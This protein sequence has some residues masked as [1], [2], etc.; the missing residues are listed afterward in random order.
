MTRVDGAHVLITGASRGIGR[1]LATEMARRGARVTLV[2]RD[3]D[4]L[5]ALAR[6]TGGIVL[7]ADLTDRATY[8]H[9][10]SRAE[11]RLGHVDVLINN[12]GAVD[13][14]SIDRQTQAQ[15]RRAFELNLLAPVELT[16]Q[17]LPGMV[18]RRRGHIVNVGSIAAYGAFPGLVAYASAK[19]GLSHFTAGLRVDLRGTGVRVTHVDVGPVDTDALANAKSHPPTAASYRRAYRAR[20]LAVQSPETA[21]AR[22]V[23]GIS[24]NARTVRVLRRAAPLGL[25]VEAPRRAV[26]LLSAGTGSV[27]S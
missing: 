2:A 5:A 23:Q 20:L 24:R 1:R 15:T 14:E 27:R 17:A 22:I 10:V 26:E 7:P 6:Q 18:R 13:A 8:D 11:D 12:A 9:L 16:R 21:A 19:A 25:L 3:V 4:A